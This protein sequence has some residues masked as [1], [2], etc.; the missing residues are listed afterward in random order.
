MAYSLPPIA[1]TGEII[2]AAWGNDVRD[3]LA[4]LKDEVDKPFAEDI[5]ENRTTLN[6]TEAVDTTI[7]RP[8]LAGTDDEWGMVNFGDANALEEPTALLRF[9]NGSLAATLATTGTVRLGGSL[10]PDQEDFLYVGSTS[11]FVGI[12]V[13]VEQE[14]GGSGGN[15]LVLQY[16]NGSTWANAS[17]LSDGTR[18]SR[19]LARDGEITWSL[20]SDW[21]PTAITVNGQRLYWVRLRP[22]HGYQGG[23]GGVHNTIGSSATWSRFVLQ[24]GSATTGQ[25]RDGAWRTV[26]LNDLHDSGICVPV[27]AGTALTVTNSMRFVI[28]DGIDMFLT[29]ST[30]SPVN[31]LLATSMTGVHSLP[32]SVKRITSA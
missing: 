1:V 16:W 9:D 2:T 19:T 4:F 26:R 5:G 15:E 31:L 18:V 20:P 10:R 7:E 14:S 21:A 24:S 22:F 30:N 17:N 29:V 13:V 28:G 12:T 3:A 23:P 27:A 25:A 6:G 11:T 32:L 8:A